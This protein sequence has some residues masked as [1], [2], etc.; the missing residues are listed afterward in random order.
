M[1]MVGSTRLVERIRTQKLEQSDVMLPTVSVVVAA[2]NEA[3]N[4]QR[5][6][7]A[8]FNQNYPKEK[9][10]VIVVDD[11]SS[12]GTWE[13]VTRAQREHHNFKVLRISAS[14]EDFAP[15]KRA[16]DQGIRSS[17][18]EIILL[19]DADCTPPPPWVRTMVAFYRDG[20]N[21]VLGYS[22]YRFDVPTPNWIRGMLALDYFS[23][24][25]IA[26]A[27][28]GLGRPLTATG[29]NLSYRREIFLRAE[30]FEKI[31]RWVS[32]DDDL[33]VHLT[34]KE[35]LG[36]YSFALA[37]EA[38]VPAAAPTTW[39]QF[40]H[41]RI[42]YA[43]KGTHYQPSM[44][45]GLIAVYLLNGYIA[46]SVVAIVLAWSDWG[47]MGIAAWCI[48]SAFEYL[49]LRQ[50]AIA[51]GEQHLLPYF[52]PTAL[53][54]PFY[55]TVFG[56]LGVLGNFQWKGGAFRKRVQRKREGFEH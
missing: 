31:K 3:H 33:F 20:V 14:L 15:K 32:G 17:S 12:D 30:G 2:R 43:S 56:F 8:L 50:S 37:G 1:L 40:W 53:L 24:G 25:A 27:S 21:V 29:T 7:P 19:T 16:L 9:I 54:H 35:R 10:E 42:R 46:T 18:G 51:F 4:L 13:V 38:Y 45:L 49:F 26:A 11:R 41:Q 52:L 28:I 47:W 55:V 39:K 23:L 6:L 48:K 36:A 44:V 34:A 5:L 22:P